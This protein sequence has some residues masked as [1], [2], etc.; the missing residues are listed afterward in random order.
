MNRINK[1]GVEIEGGWKTRPPRYHQDGSVH[2][3]NVQ[4][5]G[6]IVSRPMLSR[7]DVKRFVKNHYPDRT[8]ISCGF[9]IHVSFKKQSDY[10]K[11]MTKKFYNVFLENARE[12]GKEN[13][14]KKGS[15]FW[16]R[17]DGKNNWCK[18][19]IGKDSGLFLLSTIEK[20]FSAHGKCG[21][22]YF[23]LNFCKDAHNTVECRLFPTFQ[24]H[25]LAE[26]AIDFFWNLCNNYVIKTKAVK[27]L[28]T[29]KKVKGRSI[30]TIRSARIRDGYGWCHAKDCKCLFNR[31]RLRPVKICDT[32]KRYGVK[33]AKTDYNQFRPFAKVKH[34]DE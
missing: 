16:K 3:S 23:H 2:G 7:V 4:F 30:S 33:M 27:K 21:P 5:Y 6:E 22:R 13:K 20:Q 28:V 11:L 9:H 34:G 29:I 26:K 10:D 25:E 14:I 24:K 19:L 15:Y 1:M 12:W 18:S 17:L 8:N 31:R 32:C